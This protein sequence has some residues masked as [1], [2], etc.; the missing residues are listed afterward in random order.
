MNVIQNLH[1]RIH[2]KRAQAH[3]SELKSKNTMSKLT[4]EDREILKGNGGKLAALLTHRKNQDAATVANV[5]TAQN[6]AD[7]FD[8]MDKKNLLPSAI[9]RLTNVAPAKPAATPAATR[10]AAKP[11]APSNLTGIARVTAAFQAQNASKSKRTN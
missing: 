11:A 9:A 5:I 1:H 6:S 2:I 8:G 10:P 4:I 3:L 7:P